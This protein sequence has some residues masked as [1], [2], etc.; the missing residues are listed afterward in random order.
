[1][2]ESC[3]TVEAVELSKFV[4]WAVDALIKLEC[5]DI[6]ILIK[7]ECVDIRI[8]LECVDNRITI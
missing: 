8:K 3:I 6:R 1:M 2:Y 5:V 7:L 4:P